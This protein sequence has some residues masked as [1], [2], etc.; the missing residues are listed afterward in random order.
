MV[1]QRGAARPGS[2][3]RR[4]GRQNDD[5]W[6]RSAQTLTVSAI[7]RSFRGKCGPGGPRDSRSATPASQKQA[8]L[9]TQFWGPAFDRGDYRIMR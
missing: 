2:E 5:D 9:R 1:R 7:R 4:D 8:C 6:L 3:G